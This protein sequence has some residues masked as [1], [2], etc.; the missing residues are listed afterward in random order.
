MTCNDSYIL[1]LGANVK[2]CNRG[3]NAITLGLI[4]RLM[5]S[6]SCRKYIILQLGKENL[7]ENVSISVDKVIVDIEIKTFTK[8]C[9]AKSIVDS[10]FKQKN[11]ELLH[12]IKKAHKCYDANEGDS[13]SDIYGF[14]RFVRHCIDSVSVLLAGQS[15]VFLPQTIGPFYYTINKAVAKF[16]LSKLDKIYVRDKQS[17][18][19][20][21]DFGLSFQQ[22][23]DMAFFLKPSPIQ[24]DSC[25]CIG[26][27][28][29]G[30]LF[31]RGYGKL[32]NKF[33]LYKDFVKKLI[34]TFLAMDKKV[35][36]I[37]HVYSASSPSTE[38][39]LTACESIVRELNDKKLDYIKTEYDAGQLK[40]IISTMDFF[41]GTRM[42][43]CIA[44]LSTSVPAVGLS[45]SRKFMGTF[46]VF[47]QADKVIE[48]NNHNEDAS[49]QN[50]LS[51]YKNKVAI[52][53]QLLKT[54]E[55][56][57]SSDFDL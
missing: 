14:K 2:S 6:Y 18:E 33:S 39:D 15:L 32:E 48:L 12:I 22:K 52:K 25:D 42:H 49:I 38:D 13:F 47:N 45:Y 9:Y 44:A 50:I 1:L 43:S 10:I 26:I 4:D 40:Y 7:S 27:N 5:K 41:I 23:P 8:L 35:I 37:P 34:S 31:Y 51:F 19:L 36:L 46:E 21:K 53:A 11:N 30:L 16:I 28:I 56:I 29:S 17:G 55:L 20:L 57:R 54:N 24:Y 3:I